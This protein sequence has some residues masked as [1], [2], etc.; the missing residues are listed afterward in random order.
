M[1]AIHGG[2][3]KMPELIQALN[4]ELRKLSDAVREVRT[5]PEVS[6][7]LNMAGFRIR[8]LGMSKAS[9]DATPRS[10]LET[11]ALF[12]NDLG[13]HVAHSTILAKDGVRSA[14]LA[15]DGDDLVPLRQLKALLGAGAGAPDALL[16][17]N[18]E[19]IAL[20]HKLFY[21]FGT[22]TTTLVCVNG[23]NGLKSYGTTGSFIRV[24]G[25]T[26]AFSLSGL[27]RTTIALG[28]NAGQII[29]L[30]NASNYTMTLAH[31]DSATAGVSAFLLPQ[32]SPTS[33]GN[34]VVRRFGSI[35]MYYSVFD[36]RWICA[37]FA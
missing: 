24:I 17:T 28:G 16:T 26:A 27:R 36:S 14:S 3:T 35:V 13:Q 37:S 21:S 29:V 10:E 15:R 20:G 22:S 34:M 25:P 23:V 12:E 33:F 6:G 4:N 2:I 30:Y 7:D 31:N 18:V 19:Q 1:M 5:K 9:G 32:A 8:N 11:R